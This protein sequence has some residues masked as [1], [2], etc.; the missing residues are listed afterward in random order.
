[1]KIR[2]QKNFPVLLFSLLLFV[3]TLVFLPQ[4][5]P[6]IRGVQ[7]VYR[8]QDFGL[9]ILRK[10]ML[11]SLASQQGAENPGGWNGRISESGRWVRLTP[12]SSIAACCIT[13]RSD[14][15]QGAGIR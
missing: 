5:E 9:H 4:A 3:T 10:A 7:D 1:M 8:E 12:G 11:V 6:A 13:Y 14:R 2:Y 15:R